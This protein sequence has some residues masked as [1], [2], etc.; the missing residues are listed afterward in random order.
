MFQ[1]EM[2]VIPCKKCDF[3]TT[4]QQKLKVHVVRKHRIFRDEEQFEC[5]VC[6]GKTS[7][8]MIPPLRR[9]RSAANSPVF[10][11]IYN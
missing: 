6:S 4:V 3:E 8:K 10:S 7:I 9:I 1:N 5:N 2:S 11:P